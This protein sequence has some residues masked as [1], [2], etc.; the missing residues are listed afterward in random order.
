MTPE[1]VKKFIKVF[2]SLPS[3]GPRQATRL[4]FYL[5]GLGKASLS[6]VSDAVASLQE[7]KRCPDCFFICQE[8]C[9]ICSDMNRRQDIVAVLEKETD[10]ISLEQAKKYDGVYLVLGEL[11]KTGILNPEQKLKIAHLKSRGPFTE[12]VL[13]I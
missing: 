5:V 10:L 9:P 6:D 1:S 12:I 2:S 4:A 7:L 13:A 8:R 3:I 11:D